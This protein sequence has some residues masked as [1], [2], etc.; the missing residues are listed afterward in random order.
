M[1]TF[2]SSSLTQI[3]YIQET[4]FGTTPA[5]GNPN[6]LRITGESLDYSVEK[7]VSEE[8]N[9]D[10][11]STDNIQVSAS[12]SGSLEVEFSFAEYDKLMQAALM[13]TWTSMGTAGITTTFSATIATGTIT[14][15]VATSG[16]NAFTNLV[17]GQWFTLSGTGTANDNK[18]FR[19]SKSVAPTS[20]VITLDAATPGTAGGP[21]ASTTLKASRLSNG[22]LLRTFSIEKNFTDV[23]EFFCYRGQAVNSFSLSLASGSKTTASFNFMGRDAVA[24]DDTMLPGVP[25]ASTSN[26]VMSGVS[27]TSC[28]MWANGTPMTGVYVNSITL[29]YDNALRSINALCV[30]LGA[31]GL[32]IGT[33]AVT[34]DIELYFTSGRKFFDEFLANTNQE[35][36]FSAIDTDGQGY[37]FTLPKANVASYKVSA[38]GKDTDITATVQF[39]GLLDK[40]ATLP[41]NRKVLFIDRMG[42]ALV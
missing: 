19:V 27:G 30:G 38:G 18:L 22:S 33:I 39:T 14:A 2:A 11:A 31:V 5:V 26:R 34:L 9:A 6:E 13:G 17:A 35:I 7:T 37:T 25:V 20:T 3:R 16:A 4:V 36:A 29:N 21:F 1:P 15:S 42:A 24:D 10:R 32:G 40:G 41:A 23:D 28:A 12:T 8:L